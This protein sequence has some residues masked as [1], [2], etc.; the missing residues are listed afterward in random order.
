MT[1]RAFVVTALLAAAAIVVSGAAGD[2]PGTAITGRSWR[3]STHSSSSTRRAPQLRQPVRRLGR[4]ERTLKNRRP[5]TIQ[6]GQGGIPYTCLLLNDVNLTSP[7]LPADCTDTTTGATFM[8]HF[9]NA[10]FSIEAL[11]PTTAKTCPPPGASSSVG[12]K[13]GTGDPGGCTRD[14]V[15]RFYQSPLRP[16]TGG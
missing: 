3:R 10:P 2:Q 1:Y 13:D 4:H 11:I 9:A 14:L 6:V 15:N 8:S 7:P 12:F 5:R 16:A